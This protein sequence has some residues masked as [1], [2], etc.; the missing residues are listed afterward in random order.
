MSAFCLDNATGVLVGQVP[1]CL[2]NFLW[3][4]PLSLVYWVSYL[5]TWLL[6]SLQLRFLKHVL[7]YIL[8]GSGAI[9]ISRWVKALFACLLTITN[10]SLPGLD[11]ADWSFYHITT[12]EESETYFFIPFRKAVYVVTWIQLSL[13]WWCLQWMRNQGKRHP[14]MFRTG[15]FP[16]HV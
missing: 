15:Q 8:R 2:R 10:V 3:K 7:S 14:S 1:H 4:F 12:K 16:H 6:G 11:K 13:P 9:V 5:A